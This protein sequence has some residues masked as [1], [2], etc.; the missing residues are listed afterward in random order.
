MSARYEVK[1][2]LDELLTVHTTEPDVVAVQNVAGL[3][4]WVTER[5][6][7]SAG[8]AA[9]I[10]AALREAAVAR[11]LVCRHCGVKHCPAC[12]RDAGYAK[13]KRRTRYKRKGE[14][15]YDRPM[16]LGAIELA[17][18]FVR[19]ERRLSLGCCDECWPTVRPVLA[20][21]LTD[22]RAEIAEGITGHAPRWKRYRRTR[23]TKCNW[24]GHE[25]EMGKRR[26]IMGAGWYPAICP[27][28][29]ATNL[30][31]IPDVIERVDGYEVVPAE[32]V[33]P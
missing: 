29:D 19:I 5:F 25:G 31:F 23:C 6:A 21:L 17:D 28:C 4:R 27:A 8:R 12:G 11:E 24:R 22:T 33:S 30:A 14:D 10:V 32:E 9:V 16:S 13:V 20:E 1:L 15:D 3:E 26:T 7:V 18:R 2:T